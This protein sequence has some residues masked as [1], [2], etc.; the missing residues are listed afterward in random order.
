M[1][2]TIINLLAQLRYWSLVDQFGEIHTRSGVERQVARIA[3]P[4]EKPIGSYHFVPPAGH[5]T[6]SRVLYRGKDTYGDGRVY[7]VFCTVGAPP[8]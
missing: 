5:Y 8:S 6:V 7:W 2:K 4:S 3:S 1:A